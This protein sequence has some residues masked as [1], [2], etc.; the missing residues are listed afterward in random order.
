MN[1]YFYH[2]GQCNWDLFGT[3]TFS[4]YQFFND[5]ADVRKGAGKRRSAAFAMLREIAEL[6]GTRWKNSHWVLRSELGEKFG[7]PHYHF[8]YRNLKRKFNKTTHNCKR[9]ESFWHNKYKS[10]A[11]VRP[12]GKWIDGAASYTV[13]EANGYEQRKFGTAIE[14]EFSKG[15]RSML[16]DQATYNDVQQEVFPASEVFA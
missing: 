14:V 5:P 16:L 15:F 4:D 13:K 8:L 7:R 3:L 2:I 11:Q 1:P 6:D 12:F 9:L 10:W